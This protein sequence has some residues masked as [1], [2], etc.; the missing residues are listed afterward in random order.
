FIGFHVAQTLKR[1]GDFCIGID[2]FNSYYD[3]MLKRARQKILLDCEIEVLPIDIRDERAICELIQEQN[4]T[5]IVHLAAQASVR[6]SFKAPYD[7]VE[8]N[9]KGFT[10]ILECCRR[11]S[12]IPLVYASSSSV[13]GSHSKIPFSTEEKT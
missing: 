8:A 5:H 7:Y 4:I 6:H 9:L 2:N 10:S 3:P 11:F 12:H 1:R 13:Y